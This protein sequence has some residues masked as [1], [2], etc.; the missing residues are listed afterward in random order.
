MNT[1]TKANGK[2]QK[3]TFG[4]LMDALWV[5]CSEEKARILLCWLLKES[6]GD[7]EKA[8]A[9]LPELINRTENPVIAMLAQQALEARRRGL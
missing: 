7:Y 6:M 5:L 2:K 3:P 1:R 8:E 4:Q 9:N